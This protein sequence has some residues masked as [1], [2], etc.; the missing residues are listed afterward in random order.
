M[1]S[2]SNTSHVATTYGVSVLVEVQSAF[3]TAGAVIP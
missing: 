2:V 1:T 3:T